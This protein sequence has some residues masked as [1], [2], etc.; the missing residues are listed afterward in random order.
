MIHS[1][2]RISITLKRTSQ[3]VP[4]RY[5]KQQ[6]KLLR[7]TTS[8]LRKDRPTSHKEGRLTDGKAIN[9]TA[10]TFYIHFIHFHHLK[11]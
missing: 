4:L 8:F 2:A 3:Q 6:R 9:S 11:Y 1:W 5:L 10:A 7:R